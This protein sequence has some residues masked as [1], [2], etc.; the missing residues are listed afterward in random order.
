MKMIDQVGVAMARRILLLAV[1]AG[2]TAPPLVAQTPPVLSSTPTPP[3]GTVSEPAQMSGYPLQVGDLPPGVLSVRVIRRTFQ[4]NMAGE[5]VQLREDGSGRIRE[6][7]TGAD[8]RARFEGL[9]VGRRV[10]LRATIGVEQ[11][12]SQNFEVPSQGGVR[13]VLVAGIG[14]G[15]SPTADWSVARPLADP[16]PAPPVIATARPPATP[17]IA[18]PTLPRVLFLL[19][20]GAVFVVIGVNVRRREAAAAS[21]VAAGPREVAPAEDD[22]RT[23]LEDLVTLERHYRSGRL[24]PEEYASRRAQLM[25]RLLVLDEPDAPRPAAAPVAS[26]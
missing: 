25:D 16:A 17:R 3:P 13:M 4:E 19:A 22:R 8:G 23:A 5:R 26:S 7:S 21:A 2:A 9:P 24:P 1:A 18:A 6:A 15:V 20:L 12:E 11:L 10:Q 14:A